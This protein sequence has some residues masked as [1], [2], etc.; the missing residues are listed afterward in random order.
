MAA[1]KLFLV[2]KQDVVVQAT[3]YLVRA[4]DEDHAKSLVDNG[5]YIEETKPETLDTLESETVNV[6]EI[7]P[8]GIGQER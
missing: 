8:E 1:T 2:I 5:M 7:N 4:H 6:T 3:S